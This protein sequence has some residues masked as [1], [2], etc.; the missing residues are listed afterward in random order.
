[1]SGAGLEH[2]GA[3][4]EDCR[5]WPLVTRVLRPAGLPD[6]GRRP[7]PP[8]LLEAM[9]RAGNGFECW[10]DRVEHTRYCCR[11]IRIRGKVEQMD[12][13]VFGG[14]SSQLCASP[15]STFPGISLRSRTT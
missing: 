8:I 9:E 4:N 3:W 1:M 13:R 15:A 10:N 2:E 6:A 11:P 5:G 7:Y 12:L 14:E